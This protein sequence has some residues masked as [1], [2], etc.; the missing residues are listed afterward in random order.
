MY[1]ICGYLLFGG[2]YYLVA[3]ISQIAHYEFNEEE[4]DNENKRHKLQNSQKYA[5]KDNDNG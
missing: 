2:I 4:P 3:V 5:K 1:G